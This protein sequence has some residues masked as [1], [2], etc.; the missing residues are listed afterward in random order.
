M[1]ARRNISFEKW[2]HMSSRIPKGGYLS[3]KP[4]QTP[5][6]PLIQSLL[7]NLDLF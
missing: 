6:R 1:V 2:G 5:I 3:R 4:N 7:N